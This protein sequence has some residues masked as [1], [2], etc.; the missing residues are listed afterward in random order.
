MTIPGRSWVALTLLM[1]CS[2]LQREPKHNLP[3]VSDGFR[4]FQAAA[5]ASRR[6][7][8]DLSA[9]ACVPQAGQVQSA[10]TQMH[11]QM[12]RN[13]IRAAITA[14]QSS[15]RSI[16]VVLF[17]A[18]LGSLCRASGHD[19]FNLAGIAWQLF[20]E[21]ADTGL[22]NEHVVFNADAEVLLRNVN[23]R[24]HGHHLARL[25]RP[26]VLA[27]IV[28]IKTDVLAESVDV[29]LAERFSVQISA[30]RIDVVIGDLL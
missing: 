10:F 12:R 4:K 19:F 25:E 15:A 8:N 7:R 3:K 2:Q 22:R 30:M 14:G 24:L 23:A 27:G 20:A 1:F 17:A 18:A 29:V 16:G 9:S 13:S 5:P 6:T 28:Y 21:D 26:A 11:W